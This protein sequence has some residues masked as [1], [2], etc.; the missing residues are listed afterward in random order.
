MA[1]RLRVPEF[2]L[3]IAGRSGRM[4][5]GSEVYGASVIGTDRRRVAMGLLFV[6]ISFRVAVFA[7]LGRGGGGVGGICCL[8]G[9]AANGSGAERLCFLPLGG[10]F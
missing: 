10:S 9:A 5:T 3:V 4:S 7:L 8:I 2:V 1:L 6:K